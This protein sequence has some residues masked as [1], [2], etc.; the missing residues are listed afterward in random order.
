[1]GEPVR[2]VVAP[3]GGPGG[4]PVDDAIHQAHDGFQRAL[5]LRGVAAHPADGGLQRAETLLASGRRTIP[6]YCSGMTFVIRCRIDLE[7]AVICAIG[8]VGC[9]RCFGGLAARPTL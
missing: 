7:P 5:Q 6:A 3:A 2:G 9:R 8:V 4:E 1:M